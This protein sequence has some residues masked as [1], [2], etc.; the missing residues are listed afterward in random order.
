MLV[1]KTI[2]LICAVF[3]IIGFLTYL[4][5]Q[6]AVLARTPVLEV[7]QPKDWRTVTKNHAFTISG[8]VNQDSRVFLNNQELFVNEQGKFNKDIILLKGENVLNFKAV[9]QRGKVTYVQRKVVRQ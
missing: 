8:Q 1:P 9:N 6:V 3:L 2:H 4:G 7:N 5:F